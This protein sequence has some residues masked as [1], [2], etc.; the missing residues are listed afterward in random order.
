MN[1][2]THMHGITCLLV[3]FTTKGLTLVALPAV[4]GGAIALNRE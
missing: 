3:D 4:S 1:D 2:S